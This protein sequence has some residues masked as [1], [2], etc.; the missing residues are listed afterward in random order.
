MVVGEKVPRKRRNSNKLAKDAI[1]DCSTPKRG[2]K[3]MV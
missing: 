2:K 3:M 1:V